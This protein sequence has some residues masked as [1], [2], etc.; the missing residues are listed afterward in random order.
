MDVSV[1]FS[2]VLHFYTQQSLSLLHDL[3]R[4]PTQ[5]TD[6][7]SVWLCTRKIREF[8]IILA[9][10]LGG[11][12]RKK[13]EQINQLKRKALNLEQK[14]HIVNCLG[15]DMVMLRFWVKGAVDR[16]WAVEEAMRLVARRSLYLPSLMSD[17]ILC[18]KQPFVTRRLTKEQELLA[19]EILRSKLSL[20]FS[21]WQNTGEIK[22]TC[23]WEIQSGGM[24]TLWNF[25]NNQTEF[26][27]RAIFDTKQWF[28]IE[29][30]LFGH[31]DL[32]AFREILQRSVKIEAG[33]ANAPVNLKG[34]LF[35]KACRFASS[36]RLRQWCYEAHQLKSSSSSSPIQG[37]EISIQG[38]AT[39]MF[40]RN[41]KISVTVNDH[42][43][44][45]FEKFS[46]NSEILLDQSLSLDLSLNDS[47]SVFMEKVWNFIRLNLLHSLPKEWQILGENVRLRDFRG[48]KILVYVNH[49]GQLCLKCPSLL[50]KNEEKLV[51]DSENLDSLLADIVKIALK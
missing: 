30:E 24:V 9:T 40:P 50:G 14:M 29:A 48:H 38:T 5:L 41:L 45:L 33:D 25:V 1:P 12:P 35:Q 37:V 39:F 22:E 26:K 43:K 20:L 11:F 19:D 31:K 27:I 21:H 10:L 47:F 7:E 6:L 15:D 36:A 23:R 8:L 49:R 16:E 18:Q 4:S 44:A 51:N 28:V 2:D 17:M 3:T 46:D 42:G 32:I 13:L 34:N